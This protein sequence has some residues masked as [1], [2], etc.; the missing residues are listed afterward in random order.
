MVHWQSELLAYSTWQFYG[1]SLNS[2]LGVC[3]E[4]LWVCQKCT[5]SVWWAIQA[6]VRT[7]WALKA[8]VELSLDYNSTL[9]LTVNT[10]YIRYI[11]AGLC[12]Q[13]VKHTFANLS[14]ILCSLLQFRC[15]FFFCEVAEIVSLCITLYFQR[16]N[17]VLKNYWSA[18]SPHSERVP[19]T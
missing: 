16:N 14:V 6:H 12:Q 2:W 11:R 3:L 18:S 10:H 9:L 1:K 13:V 15:F 5:G 17:F 4:T 19:G 7:R 8:C